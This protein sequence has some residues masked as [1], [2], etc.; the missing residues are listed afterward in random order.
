MSRPRFQPQVDIDPNNAGKMIIR[1]I[2]YPLNLEPHFPVHT[3]A[4][5]GKC[6]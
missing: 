3:L 6:S 1:G 5:Q 2:C 4:V